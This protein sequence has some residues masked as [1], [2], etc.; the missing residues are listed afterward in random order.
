MELIEKDNRRLM[1]AKEIYERL[2]IKKKFST[3]IKTSIERA[4]LEENKDFVTFREQSVGGRPL[5]N[6]LLTRDSGIA[7][8]MMSGGKFAKECRLDVIKTYTDIETGLSFTAVHVEALLDLSK[9]MTL[10]SI[11]NRVE[12]RHF[13]LYNDKYTWYKYR[14]ALLGYS[15][16]T[17]TKAMREVNKKHQTI[18]KSLIQLDANELIRTGVIDLMLA[19][20]KTQEYATNVGNL[21]KKIAEK[22]NYGNMIWDDTKPNPLKIEETSIESRRDLFRTTTPLLK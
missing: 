20:G 11:Q 2:G 16:A 3:W 14:A 8:I 22:A 9:S 7:V 10:V 13:N 17:L 18:K 12:A 6:Y 15:T 1:S 19:L 5:E 21:C 4:G